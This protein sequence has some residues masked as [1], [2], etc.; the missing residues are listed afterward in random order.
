MLAPSCPRH[1]SLCGPFGGVGSNYYVHLAKLPR[2]PSQSVGGTLGWGVT[3]A[4]EEGEEEEDGGG[5]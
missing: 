4:T 5:G 1:R 3:D 2:N